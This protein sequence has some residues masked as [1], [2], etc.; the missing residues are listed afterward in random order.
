MANTA[1]N[2][3][4]KDEGTACTQGQGKGTMESAKEAASN[5]AD[6]AK[7]MVS[8]AGEKADSAVSSV[9][10]GMESL[11]GT[12]R[13]KAPQGGALGGAAS[14]V[15]GALDS[16]GR[17]LEEQGLSGVGADVTNLIRRNP[18]PALLVGVGLGFLL[19]R[20]TRS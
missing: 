3:K 5:V 2:A 13:D 7:G 20:L 9:G 18:I 19:A 15:A 16:T 6:R 10:R 4:T 11:A 17:Y 8:A 1:S 12:I 14:S